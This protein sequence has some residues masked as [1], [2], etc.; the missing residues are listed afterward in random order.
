MLLVVD[1]E[2][3]GRVVLLPA[4]FRDWKFWENQRSELVFF[5]FGSCSDERLLR[6]WRHGSRKISYATF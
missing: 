5:C 2:R 4:H 3:W 6:A 1:D